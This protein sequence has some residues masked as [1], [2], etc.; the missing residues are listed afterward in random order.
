MSMKTGGRLVPLLAAVAV[1]VVVTACGSTSSSSTTSAAGAGATSSSSSSSAASS[2]GTIKVMTLAIVGSPVASYPEVQQDAAAAVTA[3]NKAGGI[4]G[5]KVVDI[6]CNSK[7]DPN[8][9]LTCARQGVQDHVV[10]AVGDI[11]LFDSETTPI[12]AAAGIPVIG[13]WSDGDPS[14]ASSPDSYPL[15]SG[16]FGGYP[17]TA[18]AM[19]AMGIKKV[20]VVS[21]D[22]PIALTQAAV[23]QKTI[24]ALGLTF[25]GLIKVP[26]E[27]VTDYSPYAQQLKSSG[28]T[29]VIEY[30]GPAAFT[31][32]QKAYSA[33]GVNPTTGVCEICGESSNGLLLG[34]PYPAA[35][36]TSNPGIAAFNSELV[37]DG[38][39]R[40]APT[41]INVYS[42]L[43]T[44]LAMHGVA[45]LAKT[46]SGSVTAASL[47]QAL[48]KTTGLNVEGLVKWSPSSYG[49]SGLGK[50]PRFPISD[51]YV[52]KVGSGGSIGN[53]G[54]PPVG[55]TL[56]A[57]R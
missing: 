52:L 55:D 22:L 56:K 50:F 51:D 31:G 9:A 47:K 46:I 40:I 28:A 37:A 34:G 5:K 6:F 35:T 36:D 2:G 49:T 20:A 4:N 3:I 14:D 26:T 42:G 48:A 13:E 44:W 23:A 32:L 11:D 19:K 57:A 41:D 45:D 38:Q 17:T 27:G 39:S 54:T 30:V 33:L 15:N 24:A 7:G 53:A 8:Q 18:Y 16:S 10:A 21:L 12:F 29:G 25:G 43:N 1:A